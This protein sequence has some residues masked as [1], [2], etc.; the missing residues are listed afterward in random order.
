VL[1]LYSWNTSRDVARR[2]PAALALLEGQGRVP[3]PQEI[4]AI[5]VACATPACRGEIAYWKRIL[6]RPI[7][8]DA[9]D[10]RPMLRGARIGPYV[11]YSYA[12]LKAKISQFPKG[13]RF[14]PRG[15]QDL[16][17]Q[18]QDEESLDTILRN[19]GMIVSPDP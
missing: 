17:T 16:W 7:E 4:G 11:L 19:A 8:I 14:S 3:T 9:W 10:V 18:E 15:L 12:D 13:T 5:E 2:G 1:T 6:S